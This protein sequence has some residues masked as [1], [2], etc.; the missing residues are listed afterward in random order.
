MIVTAFCY[1]NDADMDALKNASFLADKEGE[2]KESRNHYLDP[3][4][5][6]ETGQ[7]TVMAFQHKYLPIWGVQFH[8]ESVSTE[9]GSNMIKNFQLETYKWMMNKVPTIDEICVRR[10]TK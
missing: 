4:A 8:P 7:I 2:E 5:E 3:I 9:H 1:E 10:K 6:K